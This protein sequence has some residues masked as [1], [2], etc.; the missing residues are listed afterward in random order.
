MDRHLARELCA[1]GLGAW[2]N[3]H[4]GAPAPDSFGEVIVMIAEKL[5]IK[6]HPEDF[7][8]K[9]KEFTDGPRKHEAEPAR[10]EPK[11]YP[12]PARKLPQWD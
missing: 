11:M 12:E 6:G 10:D 5:G 1:I 3:C 8:R 4:A 7:M 9:A 2:G